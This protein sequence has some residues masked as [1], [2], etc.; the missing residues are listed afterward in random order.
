MD[1]PSFWVVC[2]VF[3]YFASC[4]RL[5]SVHFIDLEVSPLIDQFSKYETPFILS[6][7][8]VTLIAKVIGAGL[9]GKLADNYDV[10]RAI[11][12]F[13]ATNVFTSAFII[14]CFA[15]RM[16]FFNP[17]HFFYLVR[18]LQCLLA[19]A[20]LILSSIF[21]I[22][23]NQK[24]SPVYVSALVNLVAGL[25]TMCAYLISN[26]INV[27]KMSNW[28]PLLFSISA[29]GFLLFLKGTQESIFCKTTPFD[30][31]VASTK[32]EKMLAFSLGACCL[33]A[34]A[35]ISFCFDEFAHD[36]LLVGTLC[37]T[38]SSVYFYSYLLIAFV[39]AALIA[40]KIGIANCTKIGIS[41]A[42][43]TACMIYLLPFNQIF[44]IT[45]GLLHVFFVALF[46][47]SNNA[48]LYDL[49]SRT[50]QYH[51]V[52]VWFTLGFVVFGAFNAFL[53]M[54]SFWPLHIV[55]IMSVI[56][57][58]L[59]HL[60]YILKNRHENNQYFSSKS[61]P[62]NYRFDY[63]RWIMPAKINFNISSICAPC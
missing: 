56:P 45:M 21:L 30:D 8:A 53:Q 57:G 36:R 55:G 33:A 41:G 13:A 28:Y 58:M 26:L 4:V 18:F 11:R 31:G 59:I 6:W 38:F 51:M 3:L 9:F 7:I 44:F 23:I 19:P 14:L 49:Y 29:I 48:L 60:I 54:L 50:H 12:I 25:G 17:D 24:F 5:F 20:A 2:G 35:S 46:L 63:K 47:V 34:I 39:P 27:Y 40:K 16:W 43:L 37:K 62:I 52:I 10:F 15:T 1:R 22:R 61:I 42:I 32:Q